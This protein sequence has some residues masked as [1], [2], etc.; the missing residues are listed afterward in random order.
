MTIVLYGYETW[1]LTLRVFENWILRRIFGTKRD[2]GGKRG[3][4]KMRD[5]SFIPFT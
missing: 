1:S 4:L 2:E 5:F 3:R